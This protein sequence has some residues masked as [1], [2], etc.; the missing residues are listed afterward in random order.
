MYMEMNNYGDSNFLQYNLSNEPTKKN[1]NST[2]IY[3]FL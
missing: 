2:K 3:I 1:K